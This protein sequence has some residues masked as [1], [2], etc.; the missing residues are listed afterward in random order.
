M[1]TKRL[2]CPCCGQESNQKRIGFNRSGT[3]R[4][5]CTVCKRAYTL[6]P[7]KRAYPEELRQIAIKEYYA[8]A[9]GRAVGNLHGMS[10]SNVYN[11]IKKNRECMDKSKD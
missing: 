8:G 1:V 6:N 11:W 2:K 7:K 5:L 4:C 10:K 9:S 3:Q